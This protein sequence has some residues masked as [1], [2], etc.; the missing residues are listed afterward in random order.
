MAL[1][2]SA[3]NLACSLLSIVRTR[4]ELFSLEASE[5]KSQIITLL[6]LAFGALLFLTLA[7]LVF[8]IAV[9]LYFWPT[10]Q[11][12]VALAVLALVYF[13]LGAGLFLWVRRTLLYAPMPFHAT[14]EELKRDLALAERLRDPESVDRDDAVGRTLP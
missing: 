5:Q 14:V 12:Y 13:L 4:L 9:A 1:R 6:G 7:L 11:R 2:E 10:E 8:S 3:G